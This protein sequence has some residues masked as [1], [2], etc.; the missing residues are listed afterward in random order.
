M[1][2]LTLDAADVRRARTLARSVVDA[3]LWLGRPWLDN[4]NDPFDLQR[5]L[6]LARTTPF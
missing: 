1:G 6:A 4:Q 5:S 2:K 3:Y